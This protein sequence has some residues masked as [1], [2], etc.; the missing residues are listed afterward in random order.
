MKAITIHQPYASLIA[1]GAKIYETRSWATKYR[2]K[3]AIHAGK[4]DPIRT[5]KK[6]PPVTQGSVRRDTVVVSLNTVTENSVYT[7]V[8]STKTAI[9]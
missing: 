7:A 9:R 5:Y 8:T 4:S 1:C 3:I 6:L 2:G